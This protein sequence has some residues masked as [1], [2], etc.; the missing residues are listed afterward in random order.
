MSVHNLSALHQTSAQQG[1]VPLQQYD[2]A[3]LLFSYF[4]FSSF[5]LRLVFYEGQYKEKVKLLTVSGV[6]TTLPG[7]E[8]NFGINDFVLL[9]PFF[10]CLLPA[11]AEYLYFN[12]HQLFFAGCGLNIHKSCRES[13]SLCPKSKAKV[14]FFPLLYSETKVHFTPNQTTQC[15]RG[16]LVWCLVFLFIFIMMKLVIQQK[17]RKEKSKKKSFLMFRL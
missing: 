7:T 15:I 12:C 13:S 3:F 17:I 5:F 6:L 14:S 8:N 4:L 10:R 16:V 1:H 9:L 11:G 2:A